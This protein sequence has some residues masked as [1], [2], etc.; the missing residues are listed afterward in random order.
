[1]S[2][3]V[4]AKAHEKFVDE[5][6]EDAVLLYTKAIEINSQKSNLYA[7][8]AAALTKL[9]RYDGNFSTLFC[10]YPRINF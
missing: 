10:I 9:H 6:F 7:S 4:E 5:E 3:D 8:R 2:L 1:M